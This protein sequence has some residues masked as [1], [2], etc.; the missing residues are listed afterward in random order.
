MVLSGHGDDIADVSVAFTYDAQARRSWCRKTWKVTVALTYRNGLTGSGTALLESPTTGWA[1]GAFFLANFGFGG[2][3]LDPNSFGYVRNIRLT[4][5]AGDVAVQLHEDLLTSSIPTRVCK[6]LS[7][8][9]GPDLAFLSDLGITG[10]A[11]FASGGY[12]ELTKKKQCET[13]GEM[14]WSGTVGD[15]LQAEFNF[16]FD[17]VTNTPL[18]SEKIWFF[19]GN[20]EEGQ[21]MEGNGLRFEA[22]A[23]NRR[24]RLSSGPSANQA[25]ADLMTD[26]DVAGLCRR[27]CHMYIS[28]RFMVR[29]M[30]AEIII[31]L[32][33]GIKE[34]AVTFLDEPE[35]MWPNMYT[36]KYLGVAA[37]TGT[38]G[39]AGS[40]VKN[41]IMSTNCDSVPCFVPPSVETITEI[42]TVA[43]GDAF[44]L[45]PVDMLEFKFN[46]DGLD[47]I[48]EGTTGIRVAMD[49]ELDRAIDL[50]YDHETSKF[51]MRFG[52]DGED[53]QMDVE[54]GP[55]FVRSNACP[56]AQLSFQLKYAT[57]RD[58]FGSCQEDWLVAV[59]ALCDGD[60]ETR[61]TYRD[62]FRFGDWAFSLPIPTDTFKVEAL[63]PGV[64]TGNMTINGLPSSTPL[65]VPEPSCASVVNDFT[66]DSC[67]VTGDYATL[68]STLS[69]VIRDDY[70]AEGEPDQEYAGLSCAGFI[71]HTAEVTFDLELTRIESLVE[72]PVSRF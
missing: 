42:G 50:H 45:T 51:H 64:L 40:H 43:Q 65:F 1:F 56:S 29:R 67:T 21:G 63:S 4:Q 72:S 57:L 20:E 31:T 13:F 49:E 55:W 47:A 39:C 15:S 48:I 26:F 12:M 8:I 58:S 2:K 14:S 54:L 46:V 23:W 25:V 35:S 17:G 68:S 44:L 11:S 59:S 24:I 53:D 62:T 61:V 7:S 30:Q 37:T 66:L 41:V 32:P 16:R 69:L 28:M 36:K 3:T 22:D 18:W 34:R 60:G 38:K 9:H 71:G 70:A 27:W 10:T 5:L 52:F 33:N 19:Y 6:S